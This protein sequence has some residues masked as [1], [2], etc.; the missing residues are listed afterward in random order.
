[1]SA[2]VNG[3]TINEGSGL[4]VNR[5]TGAVTFTTAPSDSEGIDNVIITFAKTV[6]GYADRI[7]K[8]TFLAIFGVGNNLR[9][10]VSGNP[11]YPN[12]DW[13]S[14]LQDPTYFP[15][16]NYTTIGSES[17]AIK[18][19]AP[20]QGVMHIIKEESDFDTNIWTRTIETYTDG[21]I[22]FP[23]RPQNSS[24]GMV[25]TE[26]VKVINDVPVFLSLKGAYQITSTYIEDERGL[27]LI[28]KKM[29]PKL[30]KESN[31]EDAIAFDHDGK[32]GIS[33]N[34]YL[35][36]FDYNNKLEAYRWKGF[37]ASC[38]FEHEGRLYFGAN[39]SGKVYIVN[40]FDEEGNTGDF[41]GV[42]IEAFWKSKMMAMDR[43]NFYKMIDNIATTVVP[44]TSQTNLDIYISTDR[45]TEKFIKN[46]SISIFDANDLDADNLNLQTS[47]L[48]QTVNREINLSDI[49]YFQVILKNSKH[50][51][52]MAVSNITI[53]YSYAG[54]K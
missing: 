19:Y 18:G 46:V 44:L 33:I 9:V 16:L 22:Y 54:E 28:S 20:H 11:D 35:Y 26:S 43:A 13:Y 32:Y 21:T 47:D 40:R 2:V 53:P 8:C 17:V 38:F 4:T 6:A 51:A 41:D 50:K 37:N 49:I 36:V 45:V 15:D 52:G 7:K 24:V 1:V 25:A 5:T 3:V 14:G 34:G 23:V 48:P 10:F 42:A 27:Q 29:N 30:L 31:L 39:D 12:Y